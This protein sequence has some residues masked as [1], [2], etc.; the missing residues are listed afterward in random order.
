MA[1]VDLRVKTGT[2]NF[3]SSLSGYLTYQG[4]SLGFAILTADMARRKKVKGHENPPGGKGWEA[5]SRSLQYALLRE[6]V[7]HLR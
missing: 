6:W 1:G 2:L 4:K 3:V 7:G 5:R